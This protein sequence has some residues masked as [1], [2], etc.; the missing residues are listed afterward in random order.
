[1]SFASTLAAAALQCA[2]TQTSR[3]TQR[4]VIGAIYSATYEGL[5]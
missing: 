3:A 2:I 4:D 1:V 5:D